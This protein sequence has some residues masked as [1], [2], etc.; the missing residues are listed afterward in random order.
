M[1]GFVELYFYFVVFVKVYKVVFLDE[2]VV[3]FG[4]WNICFDVFFYGVFCYYVRNG[5]VFFDVVDELK[6]VEL[7]DLVMVVYYYCLVFFVFKIEK[8]WK[9][10]SYGSYVFF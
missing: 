7:V 5:D 3:E 2:L 1:V 4:E 6:E 10:G 8:F 9:L